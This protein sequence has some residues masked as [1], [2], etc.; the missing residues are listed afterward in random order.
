[1]ASSVFFKFKSQKEPTRVEFDGTGIS[2]F[3][4][5]REIILR[6]GLGDGTDFDLVICA[7][8]GM[9][10]VYDDDTTIIPRSTTVIARRMPPKIQG[11][12]GAAR[13][14]SGKM[15][16]HA[17][18]SARKEQISKPLNKPTSNPLAQLSSAMTEEEKM[19]AVFQ[20]QTEN[21][22]AR[23]EEM[24][25]QQF[26]A[27][28]GA[29]K[30]ANVPDHDPPQGYI[31]YRCGEK[32]HWIQLCPTN[33]NPE[34][35][36]RP[37][38]K[39]TTGIPKSFLKTVDKATALGQNGDGDDSKTPSGIMV[40]A[41]GEF[42]IAEP[43]KAS[44]EQ[45]QA[46][47]KSNAAAQKATPEGDKEV[48]ERGL[49][50]PIDKR[51]L[52]DPMKTPCCEKTYCNDCITNAL[53]E[54]DFICPGC[55]TEGVLID[56]L[57]AD[58]EAVEKMKAYLAEKESRTKG[59]RS[60]KSPT[61]APK[62]PA[63]VNGDTTDPKTKSPSPTASQS[64]QPTQTSQT[65]QN[66]QT[67]AQTSQTS[68]TSANGSATSPPASDSQG[69]Q[70][71]LSKKRPA[72]DPAENPRIP[73]APKAMQKV[74]V[75]E[76]QSP[77]GTSTS[78]GTGTGMMDP[79]NMM[80]GGMSGGG[81]GGGMP[82][83]PMNVPMGMPMFPGMGMGMPMG[84]P[85]GMSNMNGM[86]MGMNPMMNPMMNGMPG[87]NPMMG[88]FPG[89]PGPHH[90][91]N[92]GNGNGIPVANGNNNMNMNMGS[93]GGFNNMNHHGGGG[94]QNNSNAWHH[95]Q[96]QYKQYGHQPA[97]DDD[98][99]FRKPVNPHRHQNRQRRIRPSDYR[100]L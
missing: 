91:N 95:Q 93:R 96:Q 3:E 70:Q 61:T 22:T 99:Y 67:T 62:S 21:F 80:M 44:W 29:K 89:G 31:C 83:M 74:V 6:S 85:M 36:N 75:P 90:G 46:K 7:D 79:T 32:G 88:G 71:Q 65:S 100:E 66:T 76:I 20:A 13:Y 97:D 47:A 57:K 5:K 73:K 84:M 12:G 40:N 50:C 14:V 25:I 17:K 39:R 38:V 56:D 28:G 54:S 34:Y 9:K 37:R 4:L 55:K 77:T 23:E 87:M 81:M 45:F 53:I 86:P 24:A 1:M 41:D 59:P 63:T 82:P 18:N 78:T 11:R 60:P 42:V 43:D 2:V 15:P 72:E 30:P 64:T 49:E 16:V 10:E 98:A 35:D 27:K 48:Q 58:E 51:M 8:E 52:I 26:V 69:S 92:G 33:D 19:A 68:H 94:F